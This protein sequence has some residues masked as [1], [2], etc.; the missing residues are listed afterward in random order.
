MCSVRFLL[1]VLY[2]GAG[3]N[4]WMENIS[5]GLP[6]DKNQATI[7]TT[8][9][10]DFCTAFK[11]QTQKY[12]SSVLRAKMQWDASWELYVTKRTLIVW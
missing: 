7:I 11:K 8:F 2:V 6:D 4:L 1:G 3:E 12:K 9:G 10:C 5:K